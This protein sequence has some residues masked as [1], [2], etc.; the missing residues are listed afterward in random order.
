MK[1]YKALDLYCGAGGASIGL[2]QAGFDVI[3]GIDNNR[4]C[5]KR[6]PFDFILSD[7]LRLPLDLDDFDFIWASPPCEGFSSASNVSKAKGKEYIDLLTPT[8]SMIAN[9]PCWCIEN[10]PN[11]PMRPDLVLSGPA[12]GLENVQRLR[13]FEFNPYW[14]THNFFIAPFP[15]LVSA[16][17]FKSGEAITVTTTMASNNM[18]YARKANGLPGKAPNHESKK[19]MGIPK[20]FD[21]TTAE[22]G[23]AV[24]PLKSAEPSHRPTLNSSVNKSLNA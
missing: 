17:K 4:N 14:F 6:Y 19:K 7:A 1:K 9:H 15:T 16:H 11:S 24:P 10:V 21:M 13:Q 23:R 20:R 8:R 22:I 2:R 3:V 18:F 5:G 12:V